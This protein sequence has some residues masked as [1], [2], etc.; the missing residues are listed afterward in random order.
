MKR[1]KIE[2]TTKRK[3]RPAKRIRR[4]K[5][6]VRRVAARKSSARTAKKAT[7][8]KPKKL[9]K[10]ETKHAINEKHLDELIERGRGRG[11]VTDSEVLS[12]FPHIEEE[13]TFLEEVYDRLD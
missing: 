12:Y 2:K 5:K 1:K 6:M 8:R 3:A 4:L 10:A 7:A 9:T 11:F 13:V